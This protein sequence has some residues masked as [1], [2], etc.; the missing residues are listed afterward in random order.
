MKKLLFS[1]LV[2]G[3]SGMSLEI[4]ASAAV[5]AALADQDAGLAETTQAVVSNSSY[6]KPLFRDGQKKLGDIL[7][8]MKANVKAPYNY[9]NLYQQYR[10]IPNLMDKY[11]I[12]NREVLHRILMNNPSFLSYSEVEKLSVV[13][14]DLIFQGL[15]NKGFR[16]DDDLIIGVGIVFNDI[17]KI[18]AALEKQKLKLSSENKVDALIYIE[19]NISGLRDKQQELLSFVESV[20]QKAIEMKKLALE[21]ISNN[22]FSNPRKISIDAQTVK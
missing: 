22:K 11:N 12:E 18:I 9:Y 20:M 6:I 1:C 2:A 15:L 17:S 5:N 13:R 3:L 8:S 7:S 19:Q 14:S 10:E 4:M 21:Q 16:V